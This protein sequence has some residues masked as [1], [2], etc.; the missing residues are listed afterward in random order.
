MEDAGYDSRRFLG[1][2]G[3]WA[4]SGINNYYLKNVLARPG[5]FEA[6]ADFQAIISN[7]KDYLASRIAYRLDL[8]G[9]AIVVQSACSTSLVAVH[10]ACQA[11][12]TYQCDMALAG[13]VSLQ[14]PR[15]PGY[16]YREGEIF[17]P[18]GYCRSFDKGANGTV[19]GEGA[20]LVV[21][22]RLEEAVADGDRVLAVIRGSAVNNDGAA[23]VGYTAP[24]VNGQR[25]LVILAQAVADVSPEQVSYIEAHGTGT[26]LGDPIEVAALAQ[27]FRRGTSECGY[28]GLGS[29]KT[30]VGHLDVAAGVAGLIKTVCALQQ[31]Q[32]PPTLHFR[33]P[34]PA[35]GLAE[36]PFFV[37]DRLMDWP[38]RHGR[39][40]AG[41]SSFGLGGTNAHIVLEECVGQ[42]REV[43]GKRWQILPLSAATESALAKSTQN[44]SN[45]LGEPAAASLPEVAFTLS[46]GRSSLRYRKCVVADSA[47]S[48]RERLEAPTGLFD[49]VGKSPSKESPVVF[50]FSG[51]GTQYPEMGAGLYGSEPVFRAEMDRCS[52]LLGPLGEH[53]HLTDLLYGP[54]KAS[55]ATLSQTQV[56]QPALFAIEFA[57]ARLWEAY[58][59]KPAAVAGHSIGEYVAACLAGVFSLEDALRLVRERGRLMQSMPPGSMLSLPRPEVEVRQLL[60]DSLDLAVINGPALCVVSGSTQEITQFAQFLETRGISGR[61]LETSHAFHSRMMEE[62][63]SAFAEVVRAVTR[64]EPSLPIASNLSGHWMTREQAT[65]AQY[66]AQHLRQT[67]RF[68][69]NLVTLAGRFTSP[70]FLEVGPG[71]TLCTIARQ[72]SDPVNSIPSVPSVRH[73]RQQASDDA[74]FLRALGALWCHGGS[75]D[76]AHLF[77][78]AG[79]SRVALPTYPFEREK[80]YIKP[81]P[82]ATGSVTPVHAPRLRRWPFRRAQ[83][84]AATDPAEAA[85]PPR[86]LDEASLLDIWRQ[87]LGVRS[88]GP[89]D[90]FFDLGGHS[91]LAVNIMTELEK[92]FGM[93]L[94][95]ASLIEAPTVRKF[96][97][98]LEQ[99]QAG[100]GWSCMVRLTTAGSKPPFFLMHS[101]GGNILEYHP[102]ARLLGQDRPI[103]ALQSRGL[104]GSPIGEPTVED[105][106]DHY[107]KEI[108]A[109]QPTG[110][111]FMG[112][113]CFG[114]YLALEAAQR[115]RVAGQ[116]V[117]LIVMINSATNAFPQYSPGTTRL[118][119]LAYAVAYRAA[120]EWYELSHLS[121]CGKCA[122]FASRFTRVYEVL[123]ARVEMRLEKLPEGSPLRV[124]SHSLTAH[125]E[126]LAAAN[127]RAWARY[128]PKPYDGK[129]LFFYARRQP[130]GIQKDLLL[131]WNGLLTGEVLH[132]EIPGF[133]Q[134][135]LDEPHV[136]LI[137]RKIRHQ[138]P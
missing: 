24:G 111:Y 16:L 4:G 98:L 87:V 102:L 84:N 115:L 120:L 80:L 59:V 57:L 65:D 30:N 108:R 75:V 32:L 29:V 33:E 22:R 54:E 13:G 27:A 26:A 90:D 110:P 72:Q 112:G 109:I 37:V 122:R 3:I 42:K 62:A 52:D 85:A 128:R 101:H 7:D 123:R 73:P 88:A 63:A 79:H 64:R 11:L 17:S 121:F 58:G 45:Y 95:L 82:R 130:I 31:R 38:L 61:R 129:V 127:D 94:P 8:R 44:L 66:W 89:D 86:H 124:K 70:I 15:A 125:L 25:D 133:R 23:R 104:D 92:N 69:D 67:V 21:L 10:M 47:G 74:F 56:S 20:G 35:L 48:A 53:G 97:R 103:Y 12:M 18:D 137:A 76:L 136:S 81:Q 116:A 39:R 138:L 14:F 46:A 36:S 107:L 9:P 93:R 100:S 43:T 60:P 49:A 40:I 19:L 126:V 6:V 131:G 99:Q 132:E 96:C 28:C 114:G 77:T 134:T 71:S 91:L 34:N 68:G 51:Q 105:L 117:G 2:I 106:T 5:H 55:A 83:P 50:L 41:V 135:L 78:P 119:R 1:M 113:Y 118:H